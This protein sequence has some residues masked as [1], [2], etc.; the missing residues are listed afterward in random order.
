M[1]GCCVVVLGASMEV[2]VPVP[3]PVLQ[4]FIIVASKR[5]GQRRHPSKKGSVRS[6]RSVV[7]A[8]CHE[9]SVSVSQ[10]SLSSTSVYF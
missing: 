1:H 10:S 5:F 6:L 4:A 9:G 2:P 8:R 7:R 3:V